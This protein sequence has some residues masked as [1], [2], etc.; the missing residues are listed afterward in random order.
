[1]LVIKTDWML[2]YGVSGNT[3]TGGHKLS[4][5]RIIAAYRLMDCRREAIINCEFS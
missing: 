2:K 4:P 1:M 5:A 3:G